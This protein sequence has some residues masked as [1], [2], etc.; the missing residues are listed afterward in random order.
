MMCDLC[1]YVP[2]YVLLYECIRRKIIQEL[3]P[4]LC[5]YRQSRTT[6]ILKGPLGP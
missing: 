4:Y 6:V 3:R 5:F 1:D 2:Q